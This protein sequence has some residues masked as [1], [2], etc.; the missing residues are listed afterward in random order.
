VAAEARV[1]QRGPL[2]CFASAA[3]RLR[4]TVEKPADGVLAILPRRQHQCGFAEA[5]GAI[6]VR[7]AQ[8]K[9]FHQCEVAF[10]GADHQAGADQ[11]ALEVRIEP[12]VEPG[13]RLLE[14]AQFEHGREAHR[15]GQ[16]GTRHGQ[17]RSAQEAGNE[18]FFH[19]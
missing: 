15:V 1:V 9:Q 16:F 13:R 10:P 2:A 5:V 11:V 14:V 17:E 4:A 7:A 18:Q 6:E 8:V 3:I 19:G 12:R